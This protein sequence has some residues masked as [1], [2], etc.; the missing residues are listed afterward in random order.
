MYMA[1]TYIGGQY[2]PG[3]VI[4][5]NTPRETI[6]WLLRAGAIEEIAPGEDEEDVT[7]SGP[8]GLLP[9]R[10]KAFGEDDGDHPSVGCADSPP[11]RGAKRRRDTDLISVTRYDS[12]RTTP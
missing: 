5:E 3:E 11:Q 1:L 8:A 2:V 12:P 10:G 7:S 6:E 9:P 4:D